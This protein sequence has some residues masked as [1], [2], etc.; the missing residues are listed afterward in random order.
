MP[1]RRDR[2]LV[3]VDLPS[4]AY[5]PSMRQLWKELASAYKIPTPRL[6]QACM[7]MGLVTLLA[8]TQEASDLVEEMF[9]EPLRE[10]VERHEPTSN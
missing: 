4:E 10:K 7:D 2:W 9:L 5:R 8:C 1:H 6:A 3:E